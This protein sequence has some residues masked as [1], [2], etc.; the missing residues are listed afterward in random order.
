MPMQFIYRNTSQGQ[1]IAYAWWESMH[2][3]V[4]IIVQGHPEEEIKS[5]LST[6]EQELN[7]LERI[8]NYYDT[9]SELHTVNQ[10]AALAPVQVSNELF[11]MIKGCIHY[12]TATSGYFDISF[13][14]GKDDDSAIYSILLSEDNKTIA[15]RRKG[16]CLDLSGYLKGYGLECIRQM[17][18]AA[19][20]RNALI[21]MG[22]S[23]VLAMGNH[24]HSE[25]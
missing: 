2:T 20:I 22:N 4:D 1:E 11:E 24:P 16:I 7:R 8:A 12:H 17:F 5:L 21:N 19:G 6:I 3:R 13:R 18:T 25:G 10:T 9:T 14:S 23:S 15:F